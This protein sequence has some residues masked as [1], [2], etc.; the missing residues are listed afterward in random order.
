MV[1]MVKAVASLASSVR[2]E[3]LIA[4]VTRFAAKNTG[5]ILV[6]TA[7]RICD[8]REQGLPKHTFTIVEVGWKLD[9]KS[10]ENAFSCDTNQVVP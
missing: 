10:C 6:F 1:R 7:A 3:T 5:N 9:G 8:G 2:I 4:P